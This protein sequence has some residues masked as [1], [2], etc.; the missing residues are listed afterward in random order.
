MERWQNQYI[1]K[2]KTHPR[3]MEEGD[4]GFDLSAVQEFKAFKKQYPQVAVEL[5]SGSG[6]HLL[7][8]ATKSPETLFVGFELRYKRAFR[9][10][11]KGE[12][13]DLTNI[14]MIRGDARRITEL[15]SPREL[16]ALYIHFPDPWEKHRW[17]K[18]RLIQ[19]GF[20]SELTELLQEGGRLSFRTDHQ[21][22]FS[23][24]VKVIERSGHFVRESYTENLVET[25]GE[26]YHP[27]SEFEALFVSQGLRICSSI[28]RRTTGATE[29]PGANFPTSPEG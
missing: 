7:Q 10:I 13:K 21:E 22:Y 27:S 29:A 2:V 19:D 18:N 16:S 9:T 1:A 12:K 17:R 26:S 24:A 14:F 8:L 3:I 4:D 23:A 5:G 25:E 20:L 6:M 11:E 15:F 28:F